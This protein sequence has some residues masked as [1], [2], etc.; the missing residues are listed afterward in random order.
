MISGLGLRT[1]N[2][3][4]GCAQV[5]IKFYLDRS[6][7]EREREL[8][9]EVQLKPVMPATLAAEDNTSGTIS[10]PYGYTFPPFVIIECGQSLD[11]WSRDNANK[12]FITVFQVCGRSFKLCHEVRVHASG[13][14]IVYMQRSGVVINTRVGRSNKHMH[15][16]YT[17]GADTVMPTFLFSPVCAV[18][19][20]AFDNGRRWPQENFS[21][22][23]LKEGGQAF[24]NA[25]L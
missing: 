3:R 2:R 11:E 23:A 9:N 19:G 7:F 16:F 21:F 17:A 22:L 24:F 5:A 4:L 10:T 14:C 6:A 18:Q 13:T 25:Q 15:R 8:Y 12:D 1:L 20:P